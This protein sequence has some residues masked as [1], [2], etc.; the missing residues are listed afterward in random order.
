MPRPSK[1]PPAKPNSLIASAARITNRKVRR[2]PQEQGGNSEPWQTEVWGLLDQVGELE[3]Y[4]QW[5]TNLFSRIKVAPV[6]VL[7]DGIEKPVTAGMASMMGALGGLLAIPGEAWLFGRVADPTGDPEEPDQWR[8]LSSDEVTSTPGRWQIDR[9]DGDPETYAMGD[10][11]AGTEPEAIGLRIWNPHPR[12]AVLA[13]SSCRSA[14]P[15]L[16]QLRALEQRA[17]AEIDSRLAGAGVII[18]PSEA[19]FSTPPT[20]GE[21]DDPNLD[22]LVAGL[23]DIAVT[24]IQDRNSPSAV[25]PGVIRMPG[26]Y[27]EHVKH[28]TFNALLDD[29]LIEKIDAA[30][31]RLGTSLDCPGEVLN[32]MV[33]V[34]HW[35][36]W[37]LDE[38]NIKAHIEPGAETVVQAVT[39]KYLWP[40]L[41]GDMPRFDPSLRRFQYRYDTSALRQRPDRSQQAEFLHDRVIITDAALA[42]ETGGFEGTD[43]LVAGSDEWKSRWLEKIAAGTVPPETV[44]AALQ[45]LGLDLPTP[46]DAGP[47]AMPPGP[48]V[49]PAIEAP[50]PPG[51]AGGPP[52][53]PATPPAAAAVEPV[54]PSQRDLRAAALILGCEPIVY[55]AIERAWNKAGKRGRTR[56]PIARHQLDACL[57][58]AWDRL[59]RVA[60]VLAVDEERLT[61]ALNHYTR[62][63]LSTGEEH[64]D[65]VFARVLQERVLDDAHS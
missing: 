54:L 47:A 41:Q 36:G 14:I 21:P 8:V 35:T 29:K 2:P 49:P 65:D 32:G 61:E 44:V 34:N 24:A 19:T 20:D 28:L 31:K 51:P 58:G 25:A 9:G 60:A 12:R 18:V 57:D 5:K 50:S 22:P 10:P 55:R 26:Q 6:E 64:S 15:V 52:E 27:I 46:P 3:F 63:V 40:A 7:A 45:E 13:Q 43:L 1:A 62:A 53:Q 48:E 33:D 39:S 17:G 56:R 38:N 16:R 23:I 4:R 59:P 37:L 30:L 11:D 42:R